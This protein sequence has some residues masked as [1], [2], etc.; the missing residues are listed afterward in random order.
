MRISTRAYMGVETLSRLASCSANAPCTVQSLAE[1]IN[2]P[3][4]YTENLMA[5]LSA[6]GLVKTRQGPGGGYYLSRPAHRI[7]VAE[8]FLAFD[9]P[10]DLISRPLDA[11]T[12]KPD[13][14]QDLHGTD[15][16]WESL[17]RYILLYLNG[18]SLADVAPETSGMPNDDADYWSTNSEENMQSTAWH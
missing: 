11:V 1:W 17:R 4:I 14:V 7:T 3:V 10:R 13:F 5:R 15:L 12:L 9:E 2:H 18:V 8:I 16:L 6:A